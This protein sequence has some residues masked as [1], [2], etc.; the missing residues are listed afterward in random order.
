MYLLLIYTKPLSPKKFESNTLT[1]SNADKATLV[2]NTNLKSYFFHSKTDTFLGNFLNFL[3]N[4]FIFD[5]LFP[6]SMSFTLT[7]E[8]YQYQMNIDVMKNFIG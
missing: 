3:I 5:W 8:Q 6:L 4:W 1:L 7:H 2:V